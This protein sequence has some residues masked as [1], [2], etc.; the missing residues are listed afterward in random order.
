MSFA[1]NTPI[2]FVPGVGKRTA[3]VMHNLGIH[4]TGQL[5]RVPDEL[6]IELFGP[7][8]RS[9]ISTIRGRAITKQSTQQQTGAPVVQKARPNN[10]NSF[11]KRMKIA[12][13]LLAVL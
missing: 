5:N 6:L 9:V 10:A 4:T 8:I 7:S 3:H 13:Q 2:Q 1:H 11:F 12:T